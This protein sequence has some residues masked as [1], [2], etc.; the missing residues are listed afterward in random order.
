MDFVWREKFECISNQADIVIVMTWCARY[1]RWI[2]YSNNIPPIA[3]LIFK[4]WDPL[5]PSSLLV[6][7][8]MY[9]YNLLSQIYEQ[10][11]WYKSGISIARGNLNY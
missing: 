11:P 7:Q 8:T 2:M 6:T 3:I 1:Q 4:V 10:F 9:D 5:I